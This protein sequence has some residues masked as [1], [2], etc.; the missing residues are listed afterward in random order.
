[1]TAVAY[2]SLS[3]A[4]VAFCGCAAEIDTTPTDEV[5]LNAVITDGQIDAVSVVNRAP[6]GTLDEVDRPDVAGDLH[7]QVIDD[8]TGAVLADGY[9]ANPLAVTA[10]EGALTAIDRAELMVA[11]PAPVGGHGHLVIDLPSGTAD[12]AFATDKDA[13]PEVVTI[14]NSPQ[15]LQR[16]LCGEAVTALQNRLIALKY[17]IGPAEKRG[18]F[19]DG[20][21]YA[22]QAFQRDNDL[23]SDGQVGPM[24][25]QKLGNPKKISARFAQTTGNHV[26]IFQARGVLH[27]WKGAQLLG[28]YAVS[29]GANSAT[30]NTPSG[31]TYTVASKETK[32]WS[33]HFGVWLP[34]ASYL[35][36]PGL[37]EHTIAIHESPD[38]PDYPASHGCARVPHT[39]SQQIFQNTP[40][41]SKVYVL[42]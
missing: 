10:D 33:A 26:E 38:V 12:G 18:C 8:E 5:L 14:A 30:P 6:I 4:L 31:S 35:R 19:S 36:G 22:V 2:R 13:E 25:Q 42:P 21:W 3:F 16:G 40:A 9:V 28:A 27:L 23:S 7:V 1:M 11:V 15:L 32:S 29:T 41:G 24:T 20:T 17:R 34:W 37:P 39:V